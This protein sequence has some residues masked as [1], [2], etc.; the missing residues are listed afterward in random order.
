MAPYLSQISRCLR[1]RSP[2]CRPHRLFHGSCRHWKKLCTG[3]VCGRPTQMLELLPAMPTMIHVQLYAQRATSVFN[4]KNNVDMLRKRISFSGTPNKDTALAP[5]V[6]PVGIIMPE[7]NDGKQLKIV[8]VPL[9]LAN[10]DVES[11]QHTLEALNQLRMHAN[12]IDAFTNGMLE[13]FNQSDPKLKAPAVNKQGMQKVNFMEGYVQEVDAVGTPASTT[14]VGSGQPQLQ[15]QQKQSQ[16]RPAFAPLSNA[17][18]AVAPIPKHASSTQ[19]KPMPKP[20]TEPMPKTLPMGDPKENEIRATTEP[21]EADNITAVDSEISQISIEVPNG[22]SR[23]LSDMSIASMHLSFEMDMSNVREAMKGD[24]QAAATEELSLGRNPMI[25]LETRVES[26]PDN[27]P[28]NTVPLMFNALLKGTVQI[29][30]DKISLANL[31]EEQL[32]AYNDKVTSIAASICSS[33]LES[34]FPSEQQQP[35]SN[36]ASPKLPSHLRMALM[37]HKAAKHMKISPMLK[38]GCKYPVIKKKKKCPK[39][40]PLLDDP[41]KKDPCKPPKRPQ[42]KAVK[43]T[44]IM[45]SG[46]KS[47]SCGEKKK[48]DPCA[49]KGGE[50]KKKDP[51]A[52]FKKGG[53][54]KKKDPCAKKKKDPC[55]KKKKDPCAKKKKDPCAKKKK[56]PCAKK[57]GDKKK[58][59]PC[60]KF[61]KGGD[62]KKKDPCAKFKKGG[63]KKKKDPCDKKKKDPCDKK[64]KDPCDKKKKDPCA[65]FK[66]ADKK[67]PCKKKYST[68]ATSISNSR[69]LS[70]ST[71][72]EEM[73]PRFTIYSTLVRRHYG[74]M[75]SSTQMDA[76]GI[77]SLAAR[78]QVQRSYGKKKKSKKVNSKCA[79]IQPKGSKRK[80]RHIKAR[81]GLRTDCYSN[82]EEECPKAVKRRCGV[83]P[84]PRKKCD[85]S[86]RPKLRKFKKPKRKLPAICMLGQKS[87]K[88]RKPKGI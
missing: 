18:A 35:E 73:R 10:Q 38:D 59:D 14:D 78:R 84:F 85:K 72:V 51:C 75:P 46:K 80:R 83:V 70:T 24:Q 45:A 55:A 60:A 13:D 53:D 81:K 79:A 67:D 74:G 52:K 76:W 44:E 12:E 2:I 26:D 9:D 63:D 15:Q 30:A 32:P 34:G 62:K 82:S 61:K 21:K 41:C 65:K 88:A 7:S 17:A 28:K 6:V 4:S 31:S 5:N 49:K 22:L 43:T 47:D 25:S 8:I 27:A 39:K 11:L 58:K 86:K 48:K 3:S 20:K 36:L 71:Q 69:H 33:A 66:K 87:R 56:D 77:K 16:Q 42:K 37:R 23:R 54:K 50:K 1:Y 40:C 57:G 68:S 19:P 64:K 29:D